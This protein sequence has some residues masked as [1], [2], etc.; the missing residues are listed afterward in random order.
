[1]TKG[2]IVNIPVDVEDVF[3]KLTRKD[4]DDFLRSHIKELDAL[5]IVSQLS[6]DEVAYAINTIFGWKIKRN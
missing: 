3:N 6:A 1:M 4:K 2:T 5:D